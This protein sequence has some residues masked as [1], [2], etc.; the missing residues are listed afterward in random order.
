MIGWHLSDTKL[1]FFLSKMQKWMKRVFK[2][3]LS[4]PWGIA[5]LRAQLLCSI[6]LK[7]I[8]MLCEGAIYNLLC[9]SSAETKDRT[10]SIKAFSHLSLL[11]FIPPSYPENK[12]RGEQGAQ[13]FMSILILSY[14]KNI[15]PILCSSLPHTDM[16]THVHVAFP[17][18]VCP[19][20]I[21]T[22]PRNKLGVMLFWPGI[23]KT[24]QRERSSDKR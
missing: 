24:G 5:V 4:D 2:V 1:N 14:R 17:Y 12:G 18:Q 11:T 19:G 10:T 15:C 3:S 7:G 13:P 6:S 9:V 8:T 20:V 16:D 23:E 22:W 21:R